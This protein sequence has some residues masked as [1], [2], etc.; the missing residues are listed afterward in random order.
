MDL[1]RIRLESAAVE[2]SRSKQAR[3]LFWD[4]PAQITN[5]IIS[6]K[7]AWTF[8]EIGQLISVTAWHSYCTKSKSSSII[9]SHFCKFW[10]GFPHCKILHRMI[11]TSNV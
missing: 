2:I 7:R 5:N 11:L 4:R 9:T 3:S 1:S 10:I 8:I 6:F